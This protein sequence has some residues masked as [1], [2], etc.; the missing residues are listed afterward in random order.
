[1]KKKV[2]PYEKMA[3]FEL[4][5]KNLTYEEIA[6]TLG[7][8]KRRVSKILFKYYRGIFKT[9]KQKGRENFRKF[10]KLSIE[11]KSSYEIGRITNHARSYI[12]KILGWR[13][14]S[15]KKYKIN[16][17]IFKEIKSKETAYILGLLYGIGNIYKRKYTTKLS[18]IN[19]DI[20]E[21]IKNFI[22]P[23]IKITKTK[24][25]N[26]NYYEIFIINKTLFKNLN[27]SGFNEYKKVNETPPR[28][29]DENLI[30][31]FIRGY[32]ITY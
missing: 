7:I 13:L 27:N 10:L 22:N 11:G 6:N 8:S 29:S 26:K 21:K 30:D 17:Q 23:K 4:K 9:P 16:S 15:N 31:H 2:L 1:M 12:Q 20:L 24:R 25:P 19:I 5:N 18:S 14:K 32:I 28:I 3:V